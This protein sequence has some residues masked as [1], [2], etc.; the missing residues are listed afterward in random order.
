MKL[1]YKQ[2]NRTTG[3]TMWQSTF[4]QKQVVKKHVNTNAQLEVYYWIYHHVI[5]TAT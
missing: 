3:I 4:C 2:H 5:P 1:V